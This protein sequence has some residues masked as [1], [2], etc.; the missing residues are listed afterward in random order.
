MQ[1][2]MGQSPIMRPLGKKNSPK[3]LA[4][5]YCWTRTTVAHYVGKYKNNGTRTYT[6]LQREQFSS[7]LQFMLPLSSLMQLPC[8]VAHSSQAANCVDVEQQKMMC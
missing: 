2:W 8:I 5:L 7:L 1:S 4:P 3:S 6:H